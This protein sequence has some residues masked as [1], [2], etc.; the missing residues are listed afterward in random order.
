MG[1]SVGA[2]FH[3]YGGVPSTIAGTLLQLLSHKLEKGRFPQIIFVGGTTP[4]GA[5]GYVNAAFELKAQIQQGLLPEPDRIYVAL[6]TMGTAMGLMLG[7]R[8][9]GLK[10]KVIP[11]R[12]VDKIFGSAPKAA[13]L[14]R[15]TN[16]L[17]HSTDA[18]FPQFDLSDSDVGIND[19][20]FG[21][22]YALFT[23]EGVD[24]VRRVWETE[25]IKL[26]ATYTGKAF[27]A[28][29][30][31]AQSGALAGQTVLFWNTYNS[32]DFSDAIRDIDYH[33]LP[34]KFH[35]Y[36]EQDVQPLDK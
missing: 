34:P 32:R 6:G 7:V 19:D 2:E 11:V 4:L 25:K 29:I 27:A 14:F 31:H 10:S 5:T 21:Q 30:A 1:H 9:A 12:V 15:K 20:F 24:A 17:L 33:R 35:R 8:A 23:Q 3:H 18:S 26:E 16:R 28:L 13:R 36:F 22:E